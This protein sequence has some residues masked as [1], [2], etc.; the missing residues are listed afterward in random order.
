MGVACVCE[1]RKR[2]FS[3]AREQQQCEQRSK[4]TM[5]QSSQCSHQ[6]FPM[7]LLQRVRRVLRSRA[8]AYDSMHVTKKL[9]VSVPHF[10]RCGARATMRAGLD[11][12]GCNKPIV[13]SASTTVLATPPI[14]S[15]TSFFTGRVH[16]TDSEN[17]VVYWPLWNQSVQECPI[18]QAGYPWHTHVSCTMA[19]LHTLIG[20]S[21]LS[22]S[23]HQSASESPIC[24]PE[25]DQ[26]EFSWSL[27]LPIAGV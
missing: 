21:H 11:G 1:L 9:Q 8:K 26:L 5:V 6:W 15:V 17:I 3:D 2:F 7:R 14:S 19:S 18:R 27:V 16:E 20:S 4:Q 24:L 22:A 23:G 10:K 12:V 25:V 13:H